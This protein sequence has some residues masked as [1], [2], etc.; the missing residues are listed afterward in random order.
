MDKTASEFN[1][2]HEKK[3]EWIKT[4]PEICYSVIILK[5]VERRAKLIEKSTTGT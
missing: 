4:N 2:S 5:Y 1:A 3:Y